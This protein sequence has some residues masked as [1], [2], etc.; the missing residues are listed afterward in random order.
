MG[1][2]GTKLRQ[3]EEGSV[4]VKITGKM[5]RLELRL[6]RAVRS[7]GGLAAMEWLSDCFIELHKTDFPRLFHE[8]FFSMPTAS[9]IISAPVVKKKGVE[10]EN[11]KRLA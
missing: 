1:S 10:G 3:R 6:L 7:S 9:E 11:P 4:N 5:F 8:R 2:V